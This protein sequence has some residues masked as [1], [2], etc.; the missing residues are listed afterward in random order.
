MI[1]PSASPSGEQGEPRAVMWP[2]VKGPGA[3][4]RVGDD[5][6]RAAVTSKILP[7]PTLLYR[8]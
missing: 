1:P 2:P 8:A 4:R 5:L 3:G 6:M 7:D